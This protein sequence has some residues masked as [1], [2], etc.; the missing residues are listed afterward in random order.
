MKEE[1]MATT[2]DMR[3]ELQ[4]KVRSKRAIQIFG[5]F[6]RFCCGTALD[7]DLSSNEQ[8]TEKKSDQYK[9][10]RKAAIENHRNLFTFQKDLYTIADQT[11]KAV[12]ELR[13]REN[14]MLERS[15]TRQALAHQLEILIQH[16][17]EL[18]HYCHASRLPANVVT[19]ATLK[20]DP[21][22][23]EEEIAKHRRKLAIG[24]S[25]IDEY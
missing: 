19:P 15:E 2:F 6:L 4:T 18:A 12:T 5:K 22:R 3:V 8:N 11:S 7:S 9:K 17:R 13:D 1:I 10:L 25:E 23:V 21:I 14:Q 16:Y 20:Q 24:I